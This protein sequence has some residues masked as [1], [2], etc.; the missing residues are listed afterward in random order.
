M[1]GKSLKIGINLVENLIRSFWRGQKN[2]LLQKNERCFYRK[3][4]TINVEKCIIYTK[5]NT[6]H[7]RVL[8]F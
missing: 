1:V 2:Q 6:K 5:A 3:M 7:R 8:W 4:L